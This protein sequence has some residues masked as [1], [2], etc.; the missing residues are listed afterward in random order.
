MGTTHFDD[1]DCLL[2]VTEKVYFGKPPV[3]P[4]ILLSRNPVTNGGM[5]AKHYDET[6]VYVHEFRS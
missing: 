1:E 6:P 5:F 2:Y 3:G 4:V